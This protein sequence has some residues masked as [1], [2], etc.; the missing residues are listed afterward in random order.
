MIGNIIQNQY[1]Y[2]SNYPMGAALSFTLMAFLL[3]GI[4]VYARALGTENVLEAA[5]A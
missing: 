5:A 1:L 3:I 4:F 2:S